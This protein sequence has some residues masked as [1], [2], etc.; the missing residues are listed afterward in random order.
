MLC[1]CYFYVPETGLEPVRLAPGE[2]KSPMSTNSITPAGVRPEP[3]SNRCMAALQAAA[4][5]LRHRA[6]SGYSIL[7]TIDGWEA[8]VLCNM[9]RLY[10]HT[11]VHRA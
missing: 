9:R 1:Q 7:Y 2:F 4:L 6:M 10:F 5:P 11:A 8:T 3:E